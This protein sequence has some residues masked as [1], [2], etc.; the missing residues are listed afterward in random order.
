M[1]EQAV[2]Q[3]LESSS[4]LT[5]AVGTRVYIAERP[6]VKL[7][8]DLPAVVVQR[9]SGVPDHQLDGPVGTL[10]G[11]VR[12]TCLSGQYLDAEKIARLVRNRLDGYRDRL[13]IEGQDI[14]VSYVELESIDDIPSDHRDG[15][16]QIKT[17]GVQL[18]FR[19]QTH[20]PLPTGA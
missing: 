13:V 9:G 3:R 20:E 14:R 10:R 17:H 12:V 18:D 1:I 19:Y 7:N 4:P 5:E 8:T 6:Q 16:G 11:F 15:Q 2:Y